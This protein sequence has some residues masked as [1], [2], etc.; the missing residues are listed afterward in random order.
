MIVILLLLIIGCQSYDIT[1][2]FGKIKIPK[3][4]NCTLTINSTVIKADNGRVSGLHYGLIYYECG[5]H[6][7][8]IISKPECYECGIFCPQNDRVINCRQMVLPYIAGGIIAFAFAMLLVSAFHYWGADAIHSLHTS[9]KNKNRIKREHEFEQY[10]GKAQPKYTKPSLESLPETQACSS[11]SNQS[12]PNT[13]SFSKVAVGS[14]L[15]TA[16]RTY[17]CDRTLFMHSNGQI[18]DQYKCQDINSYSFVL[19]VGKMICFNTPTGDLMKFEI[20]ESREVSY[21]QMLYETS[22]YD[23]ETEY[24]SNCKQSGLC[25]KEYCYKHSRHPDL[26]NTTSVHSYDCDGEGLGCDFLC[27][28]KYACTWYIWWLRDKGMRASI[29][30]RTHTKWNF[31]LR[32]TYKD[33]IKD[34]Y[35]DNDNTQNDLDIGK[36]FSSSSMPIS[37]ENVIKIEIYRHDYIVRDG[38]VYYGAAANDLNNL[39]PGRLGDYQISIDNKQSVYKT[40]EITCKTHGC[41]VKCNGPE[42]TLRTFRKLA[43]REVIKEYSI[44]DEY[45]VRTFIPVPMTISINIGNVDFKNLYVEQA[46]CELD[47]IYTF[48]CIGCS[49]MPYAVIQSTNIRHH[50]TLPFESNCTFNRK[51][52]HCS[53]T[54]DTLVP[55]KRYNMCHIYIP[56]LNKSISIEFKYEFYGELS[57][58]EE[59]YS[60]NNGFKSIVNGLWNNPGF[61]DTLTYGAFGFTGIGIVTSILVKIVFRSLALRQ[62]KVCEKEIQADSSV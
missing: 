62:S 31:N 14:L 30:K 54:P 57:I 38:V 19:G 15:L 43:H 5:V 24:T 36:L 6:S 33:I 52:L 26:R 41:V 4:D 25:Y 32:V 29:Y 12:K 45:S 44:G 8:Y 46:N 49:Q 51:I 2:S 56:S 55:I 23:I 11:G 3:T 1:V 42:P 34:Y 27:W 16:D 20:A 61:I 17:A 18:C 22:D 53:E 48:G 9:I 37:V 59:L 60:H 10:L 47:N 28:H 40:N 7:G 21:Y 39:T 35:F 50:G 58:P 13:L